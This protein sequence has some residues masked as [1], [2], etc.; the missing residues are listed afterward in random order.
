MAFNSEQVNEAE[1]KAEA[2]LHSL[3]LTWIWIGSIFVFLILTIFFPL[4]NS[5]ASS[6]DPWWLSR[7]GNFRGFWLEFRSAFAAVL[8][9]FFSFTA[10]FDLLTKTNTTKQVEKSLTRI[11]LG[12]RYLMD[13]FND[14]TKGVFVR[15][16]LKSTLGNEVGGAVFESVVSPLI[17]IE[18]KFRRS[19][20][21][22][23][24]MLEPDAYPGADGNELPM[25]DM[26]PS[27]SFRWVQENIEYQYF[28]PGTGLPNYGPFRIL[29]VF[30]KTALPKV[31]S[32]KTI[33]FRSMIELDAQTRKNF[34]ECSEDE[35][36][37]FVRSTMN[38]RTQETI[39][40]TKL[41]YTV[42]IDHSGAVDHSGALQPV[43]EIIV[44]QLSL[45]SPDNMLVLQ[46]RYPHHRDVTNFT[47]TMPQPAQN[48]KFSFESSSDVRRLEPIY[49]ITSVEEDRLRQRVIESG[50]RTRFAIEVE[51]WLFP[52]SGV[53]FTWRNEIEDSE[54]TRHIFNFT[55]NSTKFR[56]YGNW[57][58]DGTGEDEFRSVIQRVEEEIGPNSDSASEFKSA[59]EN[60]IREIGFEI[61]KA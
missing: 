57:T 59:V 56:V 60:A 46:L 50:K 11:V 49:Y 32:D 52:T 39:K 55:Y 36:E 15:N 37:N 2:A 13:S 58:G 22:D 44:E 47:I 41:N 38:V 5:S 30:D 17:G 40:D 48:T 51:G 34:F 23:V 4:P 19:Y 53:T 27:S 10:L 21:Y 20:N 9:T 43:V 33:F 61:F 25:I 35:I 45:Q 54:M 1:D 3:K 7:A 6:G 8:V 24:V 18:V 42:R 26:F 31:F 28:D 12:N 16:S 14:E 29:L